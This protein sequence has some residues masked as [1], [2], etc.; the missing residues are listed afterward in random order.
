MDLKLKGK[1]AVVT[2]SS[3]GLGKAIAEQLAAEGA[4]LLLCSR[5]EQAVCDVAGQLQSRYGIK[6]AGM[7]V[8]LS[9]AEQI[10][11]LVQQ[12][13][14]RFGTLDALVCNAGGPPSGG[15]LSLDEE[16]WQQAVQLNLM[17]VVRLA[18]GFHPLM[19]NNGGRIVTVAS[20]SV[21]MPI[22]GLVLSNTL[23]TGLVGLM[24]T[25]SV[26][27]GPDG[28]LLN[29][30]CPGRIET[31]RITELDTANAAREDISVE[32]VRRRMVQDIPLGRYGQPDELAA[33][34][35]FLLSP[36]NS[37]MTGSVF[38]LDG[39]AVKAI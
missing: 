33:V 1:N 13:S 12:A 28:I 35:A 19:K 25:L 10:G 20:S 39:G 6:A 27:W 21:K 17:S 24:K 26:E 15:F 8:D 9:S 11:W 14:D 4:N 32:E 18:R 29:T 31:D 16:V 3:K 5:D 36:V 34:A 2:A 22:P 7:A 38:Y 30:L 23:R 37:Y